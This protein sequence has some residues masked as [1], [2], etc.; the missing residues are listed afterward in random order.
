MHNKLLMILFVNAHTHSYSHLLFVVCVFA[1]L[2]NLAT[3]ANTH[4]YIHS[5]CT[6]K[7]VFVSVALQLL[8][9]LLSKEARLW[10]SIISPFARSHLSL[11]RLSL[12]CSLYYNSHC[13]GFL[14]VVLVWYAILEFTLQ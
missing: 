13:G 2:L 9:L 3:H 12:S 8:L 11:P 1:H 4:A 14:L 6:G 7:F 10:C 5:T